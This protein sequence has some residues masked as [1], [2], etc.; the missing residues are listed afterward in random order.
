MMNLCILTKVCTVEITFLWMFMF[1]ELN[2]NK[3][4]IA[5]IFYKT[6]KYKYA[7]TREIAYVT[8]DCYTMENA[9]YVR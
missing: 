1:E 8:V 9:G 4:R 5:E 6:N 3:Y 2:T 7:V